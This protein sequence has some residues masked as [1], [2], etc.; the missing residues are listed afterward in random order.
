MSKFSQLTFLCGI[1]ILALCSGNQLQGQNLQGKQIALRLEPG[2]NNPRNSEGDFI[3]LK[4]GKLLFVYTHFTESSGDYSK[5]HLASRVSADGGK[6]WSPE[7]KIVLEN[8]GGI[9]VMSV[10]LLRLQDGRIAL[11][12][13]RKNSHTDCI[14]MMR[15]SSDETLTWSEPVECVSDTAYYVL[16]NDRA[17][18]LKSGRILLPVACHQVPGGKWSG[19][20]KITCLYSDDSGKNWHIGD[21]ALNPDS[22][23]VQEPG[24]IELKNGSVFMFCRTDTGVQYGCTSSNGGKSWSDLKPGNIKSPLSPASIGRNPVTGDLILVWNNNYLPQGDGKKRTPLNIAISRDEGKT[25][26]KTKELENDPDGWYCYTAIHF[27]KGNLV[28]GYCAGNRK[29][30]NG[31]A[32]TQITLLDY[33][34]VYR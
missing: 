28:L 26:Q 19:R 24:I 9:N 11:F 18:Q 7:D 3:K 4:D 1:V 10:S 13:L 23:V 21:E 30:N 33:D 17:I 8:E 12:Y 27:E 29:I 2:E 14:P 16:N 34:W 5:A 25:W 15:V 32:V 20:A 31:L 6:T 22:V